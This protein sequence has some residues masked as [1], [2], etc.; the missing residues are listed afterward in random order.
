[1][2]IAGNP[3]ITIQPDGWRQFVKKASQSLPPQ[4]QIKSKSYFPAT[5]ARENS[6]LRLQVCYLAAPGGQMARAAACKPFAKNPRQGV[7]GSIE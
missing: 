3:L 1:M 7:F 2:I 5:C 6:P 4:R